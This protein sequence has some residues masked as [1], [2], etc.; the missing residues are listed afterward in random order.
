MPKQSK[1]Y[2]N[3]VITSAQCCS[4]PNKQF[5]DGLERY[6]KDN[7]SE[8]MIITLPGMDATESVLH[9]E[10]ADRND[11]YPRHTRP[12]NSKILLQDYKIPP[13]NEDPSTGFKRFPQKDRTCIIGHPKQRWVAIPNSNYRLPKLL[14][15]TGAVTQPRYNLGNARGDKASRDHVYGA[16]V[17]EVVDDVLFHVRNL[18][19]QPTTGQFI[20]FGKAYSGKTKQCN[21]I[22]EALV[23]GDLHLG[24]TDPVVMAANYEMIEQLKPKRL[25]LHDVFNGHS[26][27]HHKQHKSVALARDVFEKGRQNL[28][29]ELKMNYDELCKLS[30]MM[31][32][33]GKIIIPAANHHEF[34]DRYLDEGRYAE[35]PE[36]LK[37]ASR[38]VAPFIEGKN[39]YEIGVRMMGKFPFNNIIFLGRDDDYKVRGWQLGSHG[40][41][42]AHGGRGSPRAKEFAYGRSIT[43]HTH[44]PEILRD[45]VVVGTSTHTILDYNKG[46]SSAWMAANALLWSAG[47]AIGTV[48][49]VNIINGKWRKEK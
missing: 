37:L 5:L 15:S 33:S 9:D 24:D 2:K 49:L 19:A 17:V 47:G 35:D 18:R 14:I 7:D 27:T 30:K 38:L 3:Y 41:K 40:D 13:Q 1:P 26:V 39:P 36:N 23:L 11:I 12:L 6:C 46:E 31:G 42:G 10:L 16:I 25:V 4:P 29:Q 32:K 43:G 21:A 45:V 20:D 22:L 28:E 44:V 34:L 48:Q 8:L